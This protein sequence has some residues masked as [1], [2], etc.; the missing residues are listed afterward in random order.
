[1]KELNRDGK[2][3]WAVLRKVQE[4]DDTTGYLL[5]CLKDEKEEHKGKNAKGVTYFLAEPIF[6]A[7]PFDEISKDQKKRF[8]FELR[9]QNSEN[10]DN[11][12]K[13]SKFS[14]LS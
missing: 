13:S 3:R 4:G 8:G 1:M 7:F 6:E 14:E 5:E 9:M 11:E 12:E 2:K 10:E